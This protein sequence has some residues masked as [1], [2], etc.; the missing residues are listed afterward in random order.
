MARKCYY[1]KKYVD[2]SYFIIEV[3]LYDTLEHV[4]TSQTCIPP[5]HRGGVLTA[6][7]RRRKMSP[8]RDKVAIGVV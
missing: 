8:E 3:R 2:I 5:S 7:L 4:A 1:T 6:R